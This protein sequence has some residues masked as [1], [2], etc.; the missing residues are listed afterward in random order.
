MTI[1]RCIHELEVGLCRV[2][3]LSVVIKISFPIVIEPMKGGK[4]EQMEEEE[5]IDFITPEHNDRGRPCSINQ[6]SINHT[7]LGNTATHILFLKLNLSS[8]IFFIQYS[9]ALLINLFQSYRP[10]CFSEAAPS[11]ASARAW[12][13][14]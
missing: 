14:E 6:V 1:S 8:L 3:V 11:P 9:V 7:L 12:I 4:R 2:P 10:V 13:Q 5:N